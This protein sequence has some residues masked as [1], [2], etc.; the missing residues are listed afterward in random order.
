MREAS[1]AHSCR[2]HG[3]GRD[4]AAVAACLE[5]FGRVNVVFNNVGA[6]AIGGPEAI[7]RVKSMYLMCRARPTS[8]AP[9]R[10]RV[11]INNSSLASLRFL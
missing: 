4:R 8:D 10:R 9:A 5:A 3:R 1:A 6:Q 11:M 7:D 2:C